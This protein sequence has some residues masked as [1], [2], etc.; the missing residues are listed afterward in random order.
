MCISPNLNNMEKHKHQWILLMPLAQTLNITDKVLYS[1]DMAIRKT[2]STAFYCPVCFAVA[3]KIKS[4]RSGMRLA[5][6]PQYLIARANEMRQQ[7]GIEV[8]TPTTPK[9]V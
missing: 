9:G 1:V 2:V 8:L 3:Y 4:H 5:N 6:Q 7:Y